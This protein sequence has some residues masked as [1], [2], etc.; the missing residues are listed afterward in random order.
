M[1]KSNRPAGAVAAKRRSLASLA[2]VAGAVAAGAMLSTGAE[3]RSQAAPANVTP[4]T[5]SGTAV[6][7]ETLTASPGSWT[8]T[9]P[10][11]FAFAWQRCNA[12]GASC[13]PIGGATGTTYVAV[14]DDVGS[15]LRVEVT[16]TNTEGSASSLSAQ[17]AVVTQPTVPVNTAEPLI[18]GSPVEGMT[19]STTTGTW[20][21]TSITFAYQWVR[22]DTSGGLPDGSNCPTIPGATSSSYTLTADDIGRRLRVQVTAT[23]SAG[24]AAATA[25][26]TDVVTES[27][28]TG[29]PRNTVEPSI[30]GTPQQ[31]LS[32][33]ATSARGRA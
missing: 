33:F 30:S 32:L 31:G 4:P 5:I 23:N 1:S 15:T 16:V 25:N 10:L 19:L 18:S 26:P 9:A 17:T 6:V 3:A 27:P 24:S 11:S 28:A 20:A 13:A 7:A 22:C 29:P 12:A 21:G 2:I 14:T 8:G